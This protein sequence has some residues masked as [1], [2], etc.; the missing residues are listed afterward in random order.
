MKSNV[1]AAVFLGISCIK[2]NSSGENEVSCAFL[3]DTFDIYQSSPVISNLRCASETVL[4]ANMF[5]VIF[6]RVL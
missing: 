5:C 3:K 4:F 6:C 1:S 2:V